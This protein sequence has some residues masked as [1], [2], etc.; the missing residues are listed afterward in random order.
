MAVSETMS[1]GSREVLGVIWKLGGPL[2][3]TLKANI[4]GHVSALHFTPQS[5]GV[6]VKTS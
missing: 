2:K 3:R 1:S 5:V 4:F 6:V